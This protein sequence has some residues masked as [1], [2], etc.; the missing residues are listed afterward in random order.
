VILV[1][2]PGSVQSGVW[3]GQAT[4]GY[5]D[6]DYFPMMALS[7]VLGGG[8]KARINMNLRER[9][10]WTYG[11]FTQ[12]SPRSQVGQFAISTAVRTNA[13]DSAVAEAVREYRRVATEPVPAEELASTISNVTGSFPNSVQTVQQLAGRIETLLLYGL[14]LDFWSSYRERAAA[15]TAADIA[16]VGGSKV[17]PNAVTVVVAGDLSKIEAPIRALNLGTVEVWDANGTKVR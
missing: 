12:F 17:T 9:R 5:G 14:P 11:A 15:V 10:G 4:L 8:F 2:R 6:P 16:R 3:V 7:E 13:T 1:D